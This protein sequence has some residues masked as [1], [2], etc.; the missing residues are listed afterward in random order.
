MSGNVWEW[1]TSLFKEYP[2]QM[3]DGR[4]DPKAS[5][6]RVM[7]GGAFNFNVRHV[8]CAF[9]SYNDPDL[10]LNLIGFRLVVAPGL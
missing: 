8:R 1:T 2:H 6:P 10:R 3:G 5:G 4:E 7:R 9:R